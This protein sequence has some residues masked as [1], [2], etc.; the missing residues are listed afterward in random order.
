MWTLFLLFYT[1]ITCIDV[2]RI[3]VEVFRVDDSKL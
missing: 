2:V 1:L 3:F